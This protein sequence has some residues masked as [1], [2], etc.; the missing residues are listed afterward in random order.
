MARFSVCRAET[1]LM[2]VSERLLERVGRNPVFVLCG[3][4]PSLFFWLCFGLLC[5]FCLRIGR[6]ACRFLSWKVL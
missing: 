2:Q 5:G 6:F 3:A 4:I 1:W